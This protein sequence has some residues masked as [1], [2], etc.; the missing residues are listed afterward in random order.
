MVT[1][2]HGVSGDPRRSLDPNS[3]EHKNAL[4]VAGRFIQWL[5]QQVL[6]ACERLP[7][8]GLKYEA[9]PARLAV[10]AFGHGRGIETHPGCQAL[11]SAMQRAGWDLHPEQALVTEP[12]SNAIGILTKAKNSRTPAGRIDLGGMFAKG[13]L[14]TVLKDPTIHSSYRALVIDVGAFTTDFAHVEL[15]TEGKVVDDP[16]ASFNVTQHS[17]PIG[18]SNLDAHVAGVLAPDKAAWLLDPPA[19]EADRFRQSVYGLGKAFNLNLPEG[20]A[21]IGEGIEM[22]AIRD[23]IESFGRELAAGVAEFCDVRKPA[24]MQELILTGDRRGIRDTG[25]SGCAPASRPARRQRVHENPWIG[26]QKNCRW[27]A[28][29]QA[30]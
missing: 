14:I 17:V 3:L 25:D 20:P 18:I 27:S 5:R 19:Y 15:D 28:C 29:R 30:R 23:A 12:Y 10:P 6:A 11:L 16:A 1:A 13:P 21:R 22:G 2:A 9:I 4:H 8:A 24:A 7:G 26:D